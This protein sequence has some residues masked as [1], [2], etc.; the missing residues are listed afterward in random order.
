MMRPPPSRQSHGFRPSP[1]SCPSRPSRPEFSGR[2]RFFRRFAWVAL[3]VLLLGVC[4]A[5][6]LA[7]LAATA[8]GI[9]APSPQSAA[10]IFLAGGL[11]GT[12]VAVLMVRG[13]MRRVGM[14]LRNVMEAA[15]RVAGGDYSVRV[16][17]HGP[18]AIYGLARAF[19]TMTERLQLHDRQ[20]RDLMADVAHELR[21]PLTVIQGKLEGLLDHVYPRDDGHLTEL[22]EDAHVLSR[23]IEDLR[24]LALS[25]SGA[26]ELQSEMTDLP[27]LVRDAVR[28]FAADAARRTVAVVVD[29]SADLPPISVDPVRIR[30]VLT[31]LL[32]N[33]L[34]HTPPGGSVTVRVAAAKG[35]IRLEIADTGRG[36]AADEIER[37]F[38]RFHKGPES[39]G[40][41]LGLSIARSLIVAHGG[42]IHASSA[43]G[44]GT[45][46][47]VMLP[48]ESPSIDVG[49]E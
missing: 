12:V 40:A 13:I 18:P 48:F 17:E 10:P 35:G 30:E 24:T 33:A 23:L 14:P 32:S 27:A 15:E 6:A 44:R 49:A 8:L 20:R 45:T 19:N 2:A 29:S 26:L 4:G 9:V 25:D 43:P 47:T 22:V 39:R 41:G 7:W 46:M 28:T 21:T 5:L 11:A 3:A 1:P 42:E 36:M 34:G 38:E 31:N 16:S 37:A